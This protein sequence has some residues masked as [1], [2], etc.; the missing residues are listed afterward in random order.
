MG[1]APRMV[2]AACHPPRSRT[3]SRETFPGFPEATFRFLRGLAAHNEKAW[4][5]AHR[6]DYEAG[7]VAP[8]QALV[9]A[10]GPRLAAFAPGLRFE[11][12][13]NGSIFRINRDVRFSRDKT[14]YKPHLDLWFWHGERRGWDAPGFFL[15]L[16]AGRLLL[17][18]GLH[19]FGKPQLSA[20][21]SAV[22]EERSGAALER[23]LARVQAAGPYAVGE[24]E[25]KTIPRG[26]DKAHPR[27]A[28]LL[29]ESLH[30]GW[31]G[32]VPVEARTPAFVDWCVRHFRA[33]H[34]LSEWL[35]QH[36]TRGG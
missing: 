6:A 2:A 11:P 23:V 34:P 9:S 32:P 33:L 1:E 28:L 15:R 30:A 3:V 4:F 21:R 25:R 16:F 27:A 22:L 12:R 18:A 36:V 10:L 35:L 29:H 13:V 24:P 8:A 31:E 5:E 7:H 14:P 20:F 26:F 19:T 17:G